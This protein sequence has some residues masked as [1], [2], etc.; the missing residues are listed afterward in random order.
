MSRFWS[1]SAVLVV[2]FAL[3]VSTRPTHAKKQLDGQE[4]FRFDTFGDEQLWTDVLRMH[5]ALAE[6]TPATALGVGLKVDADALPPPVI[7]A[8]KGG[9]LDVNDPRVTRR[10]LEMNAV[11]GVVAKVTN[12]RIQSVGIT[13]ALC[14]STVDDSLA[15]G[16]GRRLDGWPN[17]D[18][19]VGAIVALS[20]A[21][22]IAPFLTEFNNW[23]PGK[24]DARHHIFDGSNLVLRHEPS[25]R[26]SSRPPTAC[27]ASASKP[28][29]ATAPSRTGTAMSA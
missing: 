29:P 11:V 28:T 22:E 14:H 8:V 5:E 9:Q 7:A 26:W 16:V 1:T 6:V 20:T 19:N 13:C 21:P 12:D 4:I 25:F 2:A 27:R 10:L 23:G 17:L 3:V 18:L 24:Y 15:A